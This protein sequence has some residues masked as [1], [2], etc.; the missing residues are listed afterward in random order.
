MVILRHSIVTQMVTC[1][2]IQCHT[3]LLQRATLERPCSAH[4]HSASVSWRSRLLVWALMWG[5][6]DPNPSTARNLIP[7]LEGSGEGPF[8]LTARP[9]YA[10]VQRVAQISR[11]DRNPI[12]NRSATLTRSSLGLVKQLQFPNPLTLTP[13]LYWSCGYNLLQP[14]MGSILDTKTVAAQRL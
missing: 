6:P 9:N 8:H 5:Q 10:R 13:S 14:C 12:T 3:V 11:P 1:C 4:F 2:N 7:T